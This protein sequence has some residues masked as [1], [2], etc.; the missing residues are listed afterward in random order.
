MKEREGSIEGR[1]VATDMVSALPETIA[2]ESGR[3]S[4][5]IPIWGAGAPL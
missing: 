3:A 2:I 5:P 4:L 1:G